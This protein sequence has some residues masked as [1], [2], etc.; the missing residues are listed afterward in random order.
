[1]L[2]KIKTQSD[3]KKQV[4]AFRKAA[5]ELDADELEERFKKILKKIARQKPKGSEK[6]IKN[7]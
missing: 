4:A 1:M 6:A 2:K 7:G 3:D 5:R